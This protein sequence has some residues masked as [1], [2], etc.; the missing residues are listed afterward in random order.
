MYR[1]S[2]MRAAR[3]LFLM[4]FIVSQAHLALA[5]SADPNFVEFDPSPDHST[6]AGDGS[7]VVQEYLLSLYLAG[8]GSAFR[9]ITLGKPSPDSDGKIRLDFLSLVSPFATP[10]VLY[11]AR[12]MASGPGGVAPS[13]PSNLFQ[14]MG[15]CSTTIAPANFA[16]AAT[17]P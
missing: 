1:A 12:V 17:L 7:P 3:R 14:Y 4:A 6:L 9:T 5:Q 10:G 16:A 13:L 15:A 2:L 11:E 8:Q